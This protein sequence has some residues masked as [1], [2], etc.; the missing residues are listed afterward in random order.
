MKTVRAVAI[1]ALL[2]L[3]MSGI[4]GGVGLIHDAYGEPFHMPQSLLQYSPFHS[5]L[6]PGIILLTANG[7]LCLWVLWLTLRRDRAYGWWIAAQG[8]I[9]AVWLVVEI[10]MLRLLVWPQAIYGAVAVVLILTGMRLV[11]A[12][13]TASARTT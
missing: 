7:L 5:Y 12:D 2:F 9:L 13:T 11:P 6:V 3:A 10:A 8:C 1:A 4:A